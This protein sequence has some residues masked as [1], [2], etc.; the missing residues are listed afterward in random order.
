MKKKSVLVILVLMLLTLSGGFASADIVND[1]RLQ[2]DPNIITNSDTGSRYGNF[3]D[4]GRLFSPEINKKAAS[5]RAAQEN[6]MDVKSAIKF[7][8]DENRSSALAENQAVVAKLF[9]DYAPQNILM[10]SRNSTS[11]TDQ[12]VWYV[13]IL[14][15]GLVLIAGASLM[16]IRRSEHK[17]RK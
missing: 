10:A 1:G 4:T 3:E 12:T 7:N 14:V 2:L 13:L 5:L 11:S 17:N 8:K 9:T 6:A 16:G 15:A